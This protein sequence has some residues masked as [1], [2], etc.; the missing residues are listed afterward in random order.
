YIIDQAGPKIATLVHRIEDPDD[1]VNPNVVK[2][3]MTQSGQALYFSRQAIPFVRDLAP[4]EWLARGVFFRHV[5]MYAYTREALIQIETMPIHPY[6]AMERLEQLTWLANDLPIHCLET[7]F[8]SKGVDTEED[9]RIV[10]ELIDRK[11]PA[12]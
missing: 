3:T 4:E 2:V 1:L 10:A 12:R 9:I 5:G 7:E 11:E 6:E 8:L